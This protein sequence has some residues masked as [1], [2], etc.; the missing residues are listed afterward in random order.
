MSW[1]KVRWLKYI[2]HFVHLDHYM[3]RCSNAK[4]LSSVSH[5]AGCSEVRQKLVTQT[6][7]KVP[8]VSCHLWSCNKNAPNQDHKD[9][10][11]TVTYVPQPGKQIKMCIGYYFLKQSIAA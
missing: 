6:N 9:S 2:L 8:D 7:H 4:F 1:Q 5:S 10:I 11:E 3:H